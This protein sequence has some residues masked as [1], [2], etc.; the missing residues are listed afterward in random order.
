MLVDW[1]WGPRE[2]SGVIRD[3]PDDPLRRSAEDIF[4]IDKSS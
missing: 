3:R 4:S 1:L 2:D